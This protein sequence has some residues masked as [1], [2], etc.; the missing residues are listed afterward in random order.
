MGVHRQAPYVMSTI[1]RVVL[2]PFG[3]G[4]SAA[5]IEARIAR[6]E[7]GRPFRQA[8]VEILAE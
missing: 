2:A 6:Y 3:S 1:A 7:A 8:A 5:G 4:R